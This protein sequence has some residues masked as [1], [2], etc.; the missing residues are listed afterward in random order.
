MV[1]SVELYSSTHNPQL[2]QH[3]K[4]GCVWKAVNYSHNDAYTSWFIR[5]DKSH[6]LKKRQMLR[7][8][9]LHV[10]CRILI[11]WI[12]SGKMLKHSV[13]CSWPGLDASLHL[14]LWLWLYS[15]KKYLHIGKVTESMIRISAQEWNSCDWKGDAAAGVESWGRV[16]AKKCSILW[17]KEESWSLRGNRRGRNQY[18]VEQFTNIH[19]W[20]RMLQWQNVNILVCGFCRAWCDFWNSMETSS[21]SDCVWA[22][23]HDHL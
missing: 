5:T 20:I 17:T 2:P 19:K 1:I 7:S 14:L 16:S 13:F 22:L 3:F 10:S 8:T 21:S 11:N 12:F 18:C 6:F 15:H 9:E 23:L 4:W